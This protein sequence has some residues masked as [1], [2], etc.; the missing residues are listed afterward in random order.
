M[1]GESLLKIV[2]GE[3]ADK[4]AVLDVRRDVIFDPMFRGLCERNS[5]GNYGVCHMCPPL[6]GDIESLILWARSFKEAVIY[7]T[8]WPLE[9]SFDIEGM[10]WGG[11]RLNQCAARIRD[12]LQNHGMLHLSSGGCRVCARCAAQD[13]RPCLYPDKAMAS[14]EAYG[15]DVYKT[16]KNAGLPYNNGPNTVTFFGMVLFGEGRDA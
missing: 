13:G 6:V 11:K 14:L 1:N 8:I 10:L 4:A 12:A 2:L 16:A 15:I 9:D 5:C 7:Q 3:G